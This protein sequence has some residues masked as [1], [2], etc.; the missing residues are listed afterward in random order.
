[1][2]NIGEMDKFPEMYNLQ[3]LNQETAGADELLGAA[4]GH[5]SL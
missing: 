1:M 5:E 4:A 3:R 2:G